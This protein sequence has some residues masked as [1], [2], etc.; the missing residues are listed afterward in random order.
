MRS[1]ETRQAWAGPALAAHVVWPV[2][3]LAVLL[4]SGAVR[5]GDEEKAKELYQQAVDLAKDGRYTEAVPLFE[6]AY[7]LGAPP[8]ALYNIGRC[9]ESLGK[10]GL[11][12]DYY[13]RYVAA[14]GVEDAAEVEE[15]IARDAMLALASPR[16]DPLRAWSGSFRMR[17][18]TLAE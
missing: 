13:Q 7:S 17:N 11:A 8:V 18:S 2:A 15:I 14:P 9:Y 16:T 12:V 10:F 6:E 3:A 1:L 5:A 4:L